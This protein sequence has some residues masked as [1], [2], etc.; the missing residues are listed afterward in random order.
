VDTIRERGDIRRL[1]RTLSVQGRMA[2]WILTGLP[3]FV[4]G[5]F[6]V[7]Q[8][9]VMR[10]MFTSSGGQLALLIAALMVVAGS[11][12]IKRIIDIDV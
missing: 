11:L 12:S 2:R 8:P 10:P 7:I 3:I 6:W 4:G 9:G 5:F 1:V